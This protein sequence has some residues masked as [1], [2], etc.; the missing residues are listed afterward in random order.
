[1]SAKRDRN[2]CP[3]R[4]CRL[5]HGSIAL[6]TRQILQVENQFSLPNFD[7][8]NAWEMA[9]THKRVFFL[10]QELLLDFPARLDLTSNADD[11]LRLDSLKHADDLWVYQGFMMPLNHQHHI[12]Y[13]EA[14]LRYQLTEL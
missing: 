7:T 5:E 10:G 13:F 8:S 9:T 11:R 1:M 2:A 3:G 14:M 6:V 4:S 12:R